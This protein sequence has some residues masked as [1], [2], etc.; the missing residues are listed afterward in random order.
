MISFSHNE[1]SL[2][3]RDSVLAEVK[4]NQDYKLMHEENMLN[5]KKK[6]ICHDS[7][8]GLLIYL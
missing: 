7:G 6:Q 4:E 5:E 3:N 2:C 1:S 8:M